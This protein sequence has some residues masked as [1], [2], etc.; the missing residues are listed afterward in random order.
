MVTDNKLK[1]VGM[2]SETNSDK[3]DSWKLYDYFV[4]NFGFGYNYHKIIKFI[5]LL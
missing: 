3:A 5:Y 2:L 4:R 1:N